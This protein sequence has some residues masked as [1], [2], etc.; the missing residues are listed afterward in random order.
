MAGPHDAIATKQTPE[1]DD[2]SPAHA[3]MITVSRADLARALHTPFATPSAIQEIGAQLQLSAAQIGM[4][5]AGNADLKMTPQQY[6]AMRQS[7]AAAYA[8]AGKSQDPEGQ[9]DQSG[10]LCGSSSSPSPT[11]SHSIPPVTTTSTGVTETDH[12]TQLTQ[13]KVGAGTVTVRRDVTGTGVGANLF[14]ID[15][16]GTDAKDA[17]WLQFI[18]REIIGI[19]SD[20]TAHP[21]TGPWSTNSHPY[22]LTQGGTATAYGTPNKDNYN[23]DAGTSGSDPFYETVGAANRAADQTMIYDRPSGAGGKVNAAFSAGA[24][25]VLA[26]AH[27]DTFLV[28]TDHVAYRVRL[29]MTYDYSSATATPTPTTTSDGS[30]AASALPDAIRDRFHA[31]WPAYSWLK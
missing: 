7:M 8:Q 27:F 30:G 10:S 16:K 15:Y 12:G 19:H 4:L 18:H 13:E 14:A 3:E 9:R 23:T 20:G 5:T 2:A 21:Q 6:A 17:H 31:D 29:T 22:N 1:H 25:R 24:T 11:P 28:M 26:R